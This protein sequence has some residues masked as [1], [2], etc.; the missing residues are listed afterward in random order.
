LLATE[1]GFDAD[2][3]SG[4]C[5]HAWARRRGFGA[6]PARAPAPTTAPPPAA[7]APAAPAAQ[8]ITRDDYIAKARD[9]AAKRAATRFDAMDADHDGIL[10]VDEIAAYRAAHPRRKKTDPTPE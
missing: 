4:R 5:G 1:G 3:I 2:F 8:G 9:A 6:G 10:T 7:T